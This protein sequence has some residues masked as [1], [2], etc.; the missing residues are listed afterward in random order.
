MNYAKF[1]E[2]FDV[3]G[4]KKDLEKNANGGFEK[5]P[6]GEYV[7]KLVKMEL[8]ESSK[9]DPLFVVWFEILEGDMKGKMIFM[10]QSITKAFQLHICNEML[11]SLDSGLEVVFDDFEQYGNL[12]EQIKFKVDEY[13]LEYLLDYAEK[14]GY[15]T[16]KIKEVF[17]ADNPL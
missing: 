10:N 6:F 14:K 1:N 7:V 8:K 12:I 3:E 5:T 16:F 17:E 11:R 13:Q 4:L 9:G 2:L 15:D